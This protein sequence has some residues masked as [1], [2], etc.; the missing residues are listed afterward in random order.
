[1]SEKEITRDEAKEKNEKDF[2]TLIKMIEEGSV[3]IDFNGHFQ[4]ETDKRLFHAVNFKKN[5]HKIFEHMA[6]IDLGTCCWFPEELDKVYEC[7][8]KGEIAETPFR[9]N[10]NHYD[11]CKICSERLK[12]EFDGKVIRV[13]NR[14]ESPEGYFPMKNTMDFPSGKVVVCNDMRVLWPDVEAKMEPD[15]FTTYGLDASIGF[16]NTVNI[17]MKHNMAHVF[18]GNTMPDVNVDN[19]NTIIVGKMGYADEA[20]DEIQLPGINVSNV[21]TDLWW[22]CMADYEETERRFNK[23]KN[24]ITKRW[25]KDSIASFDEFLKDRGCDVFEVDPGTYEFEVYEHPSDM[26]SYQNELEY[27]GQP[28]IYSI[29]RKI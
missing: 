2:K 1:M 17:Y 7:M 28:V 27:D 25:G 23:Y 14:C 9:F 12:F 21:C 3:S 29:A 15:R 8:K 19:G 26:V 16:L 5:Q 11:S 24:D 18:V 22:Y 4:C 13:K 20:E 10:V 6:E